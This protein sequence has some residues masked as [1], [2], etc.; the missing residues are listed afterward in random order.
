MNGKPQESLRQDKQ[1]AETLIFCDPQGRIKHGASRLCALI[2]TVLSL[3]CIQDTAAVFLLP[4]PPQLK[5]NQQWKPVCGC[6]FSAQVR[7]VQHSLDL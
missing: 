1:A 6:L 4:Q 2:D 3:V 5:W 7:S